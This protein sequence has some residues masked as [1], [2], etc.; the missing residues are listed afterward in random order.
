M[1]QLYHTTH[2]YIYT[3]ILK[4]ILTTIWE[5]SIYT[6][7]THYFWL[8]VIL[9]LFPDSSAL[10]YYAHFTIPIFIIY[11]KIYPIYESIRSIKNISHL[12]AFNIIS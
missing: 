6:I 8:K 3:F 4:H 2:I 1:N 9:R 12:S 10:T 7:Y 5:W 11:L